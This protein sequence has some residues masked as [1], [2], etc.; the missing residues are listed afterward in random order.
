MT[1]ARGTGG[2]CDR[3]WAGMVTLYKEKGAGVKEVDFAFGFVADCRRVLRWLAE[4][5]LEASVS[6]AV[7]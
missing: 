3:T 2:L 1:V 5:G 4:P 7:T 6:V